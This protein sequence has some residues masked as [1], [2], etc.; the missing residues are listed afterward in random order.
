MTDVKPPSPPV[1]RDRER[2]RESQPVPELP[3]EQRRQPVEGNNE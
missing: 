3:D 2:V 1:H